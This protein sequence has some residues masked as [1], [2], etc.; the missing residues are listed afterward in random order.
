VHKVSAII[1]TYN[2]AHYLATAIESVI[3]QTCPIHEIIVVDDGSTDHTEEIVKTFGNKVIYIKQPN[4]GLSAAR[5]TGIRKATGDTLAFLDSD[6]VWYPEKIEKQLRV[7][8]RDPE[9]GIVYCGSRE[10]D[11]ES[12]QT[13]KV[14]LEGEEGW[15]ADDLL[16]FESPTIVSIGSTGLARRETIDR[17]GFFDTDLKHSEDWDYSYRTARSYKVGFAREVL[18]DYRNHSSNM[19]KNVAAMEKAMNRCF[20]KAFDTSDEHILALRDRAYGNL[21]SVLAGSYFHSRNYG[22]F[23]RCSLRSLRLRPSL[24]TRYLNF[25]VRW[26]KRRSLT[27]E[28]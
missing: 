26:L 10:F 5:N 15:I 24:I 19:H 9:I 3:S 18:L 2:Y 7:L 4:A 14:N 1:P 22:D 16:L 11:S 20:E 28:N 13:I 12:G 6:D 21:Y 25:P 23:A 17:I 8:D 27:R